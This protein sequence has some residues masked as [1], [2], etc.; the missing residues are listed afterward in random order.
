M[1]HRVKVP[2]HLTEEQRK[3][4]LE[5]LDLY[6]TRADA[7][8]HPVSQEEEESIINEALR[9]TRPGYRPVS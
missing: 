3:A 7:Q 6:F 9:S 2:S 1:M 5:K 8:R 4:A